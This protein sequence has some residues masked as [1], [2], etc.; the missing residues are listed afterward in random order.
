MKLHKGFPT[1]PV[2][3]CVTGEGLGHVLRRRLIFAVLTLGLRAQTPLAHCDSAV[4][5]H[6][7]G[8]L[9]GA[10]AADRAC[11]AAEPGRIDALPNPGAVL[12]KMGRYEVA[13]QP[14]DSA[15]AI[16]KLAFSTRHRAVVLSVASYTH[17]KMRTAAAELKR[18]STEYHDRVDFRLV[19]LR[20]AH[21][22]RAARGIELPAPAKTVYRTRLGELD[23]H[24]AGLER[25]IR[26]ILAD[27]DSNAHLE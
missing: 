3:E 25:A 26:E 22:D 19:Y 21:V 12:A 24:P 4:R 1:G 14:S 17:P 27:R 6:R 15:P 16:G 5:L 18:I 10:A 13:S 8:H 7:S 20:E 11:L 9:A 2:V 23:F